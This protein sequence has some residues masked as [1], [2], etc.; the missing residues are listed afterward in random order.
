MPSHSQFTLR[1]SDLKIE[2]YLHS[3]KMLYPKCDGR[4]QERRCWPSSWLTEENWYEV[5]AGHLRIDIY[6]SNH[7]SW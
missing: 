1:A 6:D 5:H 2:K 4:N 7:N 3:Q